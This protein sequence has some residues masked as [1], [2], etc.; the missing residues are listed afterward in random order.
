[1]SQSRRWRHPSGEFTKL[2]A[3]T[4]LWLDMLASS[5]FLETSIPNFPSITIQILSLR[6]FSKSSALN[7]LVR[8]IYAHAR[9]RIPFN[10]NSGAWKTGPNLPHGL[11][12]QGTTEAHR[13]PRCSAKMCS[14]AEQFATYKRR[15][16]PVAPRTDPGVRC[17]TDRLK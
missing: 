11:V 16:L 12:R 4:L 1:M 14:F 15:P 13:S 17:Y 8:R 3:R 5:V 6:L 9:P 2:L 10:L 7:N